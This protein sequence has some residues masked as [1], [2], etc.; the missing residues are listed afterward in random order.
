MTREQINAIGVHLA[1]LREAEEGAVVVSVGTHGPDTDMSDGSL[2]ATVTMNG[3]EGFARAKYLSDAI[4]LARG[5]ARRKV[6]AKAAK[7][8]RERE[9]AA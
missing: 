5:N 3:E 6:D 9:Q 4:S 8:K 2:C 1:A 7:A